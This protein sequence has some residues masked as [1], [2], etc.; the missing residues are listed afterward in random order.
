MSKSKDAGV[1]DAVELYLNRQNRPYSAVDIFNNLKDF[2]KT[3]VVKACESLV[4]NS[5]ITEKVYGK[6]KVYVADQSKFSD[7]DENE[8]KQM[9]ARIVELSEKVSTKLERV[10]ALESEV[11]GFNNALSTKDAKAQV[12]KLS[13]E[14]KKCSEKLQKLSEGQVLIS[15]EDK[16]KVYK[17]R[18][19]YVKEWRKR[20][21]ISNE[22]VNAILEGYPKSKK[23]LLDT[24]GIETDEDIGVVVPN[25]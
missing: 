8:I 25:V 21:R 13:E 2:G 10:K 4:E 24:I 11:K 5:R 12:A 19:K 9:D 18:E 3:A 23:E 7:V 17:C 16:E 20:K 6:Q 14:C 22:I 1:V 15:T